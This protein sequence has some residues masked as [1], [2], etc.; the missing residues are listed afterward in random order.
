MNGDASRCDIRAGTNKLSLGYTKLFW[1]RWSYPEDNRIFASGAWKKH[2][3]WGYRHE[4]H[5]QIVGTEVTWLNNNTR[6]G[7]SKSNLFPK[8]M[9]SHSLKSPPY[10]LFSHFD[11]PTMMGT[12]KNLQFY[13]IYFLFFPY[14]Y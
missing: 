10:Q 7:Y 8:I 2:L 5:I 13:F 9:Y 1:H 4:D 6:W 14:F 3:S 11:P 12:F